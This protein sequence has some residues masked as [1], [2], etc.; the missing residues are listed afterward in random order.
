MGSIL[1]ASCKKCTFKKE[2]DFGA[3]MMD[4]KTNCSVP[5][6]NKSTGEFLVKNYFN[7]DELPRN[8]V[9]YNDPGMYE[10]ELERYKTHQWQD[11][12][13]KHKNN[14]CPVC[15]TYSLSFTEMG[16]FD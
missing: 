1:K 3:G 4:F 7:K 11:V 16:L 9:F 8:I 5:A 6:I 14:L 13:L 12:N 2:F 15:K 10:G